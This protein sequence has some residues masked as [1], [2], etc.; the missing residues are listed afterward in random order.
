ML[1]VSLS[2]RPSP[3]G[4]EDLE[5]I[6]LAQDVPI[7]IKIHNNLEDHASKLS[8]SESKLDI[9][10]LEDSTIVEVVDPKPKTKPILR[11]VTCPPLKRLEEDLLTLD[12]KC[13]RSKH[14]TQLND[15][16]LIFK[17]MEPVISRTAIMKI[18]EVKTKVDKFTVAEVDGDNFDGWGDEINNEWVGSDTEE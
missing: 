18:P 2:E 1:T 15:I 3:D 13:S 4:G 16:E 14:D 9:L 17:D 11:D 5:E 12:V 10:S 7:A 8:L 6:T